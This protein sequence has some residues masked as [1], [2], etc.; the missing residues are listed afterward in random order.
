MEQNRNPYV[1]DGEKPQLKNSVVAFMDILG[2]RQMAEDA[3]SAGT[4]PE[5]LLRLHST[6]E[7]GQ[8]FLKG[9]LT[10]P[11]LGLKDFYAVKAF[12]DNIV[13]GW[14]IRTDGES[15]LGSTFFNL[16]F[17]QFNLALAGFFIR[18]G[19]SIGPL[20]MDD[21]AVFGRGLNEA[22][23]A[24]SRLARDP[25]IVLA[26]SA[27]EA[28]KIHMRY[29]AEPDY[30]PQST[31]LYRDSDGKVFINYLD[32][33][34][35]AEHESGPFYAELLKHKEVVERSLSEHKNNPVIWSKYGWV[36]N[37]H[38]FFCEQYPHYFSSEHMIEQSKIRIVPRKIT[39]A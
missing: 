33:V 31:D 9:D 19:L 27:E 10:P 24:A 37:Y 11:K 32:S 38:N 5:L 6:L 12:T 35:I 29:Y 17:F 1:N 8:K 4:E 30:S 16:S 26:S 28:V 34:L 21:I 14:P 39:E 7:Y 2:Y 23:D 15:E 18:G 25:R 22:Y 3:A 13:I 20:Y 36:A